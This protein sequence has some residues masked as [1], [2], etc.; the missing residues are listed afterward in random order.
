MKK[1]IISIAAIILAMSIFTGC[2]GK[3]TATQKNTDDTTASSSISEMLTFVETKDIEPV[4][5][6]FIYKESEQEVQAVPVVQPMSAPAKTTV[7]PVTDLL[8]VMSCSER[9]EVNKFLSNF[10]EAFYEC[11]NNEAEDKILFAYTHAAINMTPSPIE[12]TDYGFGIKAETV[13]QILTRFFG[14]SVPHETPAGSLYVNYVDGYFITPGGNEESN[15][16]FSVATNMRKYSD[17]KYIVDFSVFHDDN[18]AYTTL[19]NWYSLSYDDVLL[20]PQYNH[21]YDGEAI[22]RAKGD[23]YELVSYKTYYNY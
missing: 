5:S 17:N 19:D 12:F 16:Y 10:S 18:N 21:R 20:N 7:P 22:I 23:T 6:D 11:S 13:D 14:R 8:E 2:S 15:A 3:I 1:R 9:T 4:K